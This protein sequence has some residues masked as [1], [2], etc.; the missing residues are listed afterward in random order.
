MRRPLIECG[1]FFGLIF[2]AVVGSDQLG[3]N[4]IKDCLGNMGL[5]A[6]LPQAGANCSSEIVQRPVLLKLHE[7]IEFGFRSRPAG[8]PADWQSA[9]NVIVAI[10][11]RNGLEDSKSGV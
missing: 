7:L 8:K 2:V 10:A 5:Y 1:P 3:R 4:V 6:Y 9:E 11:S